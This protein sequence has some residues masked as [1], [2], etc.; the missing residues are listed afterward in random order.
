MPRPAGMPKSGGRKK[1]IPNKA[2]IQRAREIAESGLTPLDYMISVLRDASLPLD[3][4]L[5]AAKDAAP[6]VHP[7]LASVEHRGDAENPIAFAILS[8]VPRDE[9]DS[10]VMN[11]YGDH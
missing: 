9:D 1:G 8:A 6:Y 10:V 11:G 4:R 7:K 3:K 2:S 5:Q